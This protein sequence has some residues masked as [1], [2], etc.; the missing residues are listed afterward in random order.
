MNVSSSAPTHLV[1]LVVSVKDL[2]LHPDLVSGVLGA[3][4]DA[5]VAVWPAVLVDRLQDDPQ[6]ARAQPIYCKTVN[7]SVSSYSII[8]NNRQSFHAVSHLTVKLTIPM[9]FEA[10]P[11]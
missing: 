9:T 2:G 11:I 3:P 10:A 6:T 4:E 1:V 8:Y 5:E 7:H